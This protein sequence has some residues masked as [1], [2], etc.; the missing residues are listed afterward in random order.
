VVKK[1]LLDQIYKDFSK[2]IANKDILGILLFGSLTKDK[3]TNRSDIDICVVAPN[4]EKHQLFS[5]I[6]QNINVQAKKYD[7]RLFYELPLY[8]KINVIEEGLLIYS[9][10]KLDLYEF[11]YIYRKLWNDQKHRQ[12]ISKENM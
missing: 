12:G 8:I 11:F 10:N 1:K 5:F 6:L 7:V 4:E 9:P 2:V 3:N